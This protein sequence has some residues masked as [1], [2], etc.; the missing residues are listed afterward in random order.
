MDSVDS[1]TKFAIYV[2]AAGCAVLVGILVLVTCQYYLLKADYKVA[3]VKVCRA[4]SIFR[5]PACFVRTCT[6]GNAHCHVV[7]P[8]LS[9]VV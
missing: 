3:V 8:G 4:E 5:G 9:L 2:G 6:S 7:A 1:E